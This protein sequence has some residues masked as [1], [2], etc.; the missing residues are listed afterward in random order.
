MTIRT[1]A[2]TLDINKR[3][4]DLPF[5]EAIQGDFNSLKLQVSVIED[6]IPVDLTGWTQTFFVALDNQHYVKDTTGIQA[7]AE[8]LK[9]GRFDYVFVKEAFA[10]P[11]EMETARFILEDSEGTMLT[12]MPRFTYTV[13][14][15]PAQGKVIAKTFDSDYEKFKDEIKEMMQDS[16]DNSAKA[17]DDSQKAVDNANNALQKVEDGFAD[18]NNRLEA[19]E[20][21]IDDQQ[22]VKVGGS[23]M[24]GA[25]N[26]TKSFNLQYGA[27]K[28]YIGAQTAGTVVTIKLGSITG[29]ATPYDAS[30]DIT[31]GSG[32]GISQDGYVIDP[33]TTSSAYV[34][35]VV[36]IDTVKSCSVING[37]E[38]YA[39]NTTKATNTLAI[40]QDKKQGILS[41]GSAIDIQT[42]QFTLNQ[43][44]IETSEGA[45]AKADK[46]LNDAKSLLKKGDK[47]TLGLADGYTAGTD[48]GCW[49]Q[50]ADIGGFK[51]VT[52]HA[53]ASGKFDSGIYTVVNKD[54]VPSALLPPTNIRSGAA[55]TGARSGIFEINTSGQ[56]KLGHNLTSAPTW[57]E[58]IITY[59]L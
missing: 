48:G 43:K 50:V 42:P 31:V 4:W 23:T 37:K 17:L 44:T 32:E 29:T 9:S 46:A 58:G 5:I 40:K 25:L 18:A 6:G 36:P 33:V 1:I 49:Y 35:G 56:L 28:H 57:M 20:N 7:S 59:I 24:T 8:D 11:G 19:L 39:Q 47:V 12:G 51:I 26:N 54:L 30:F 38:K 41:A 15:D 10:V 21:D 52:I 13:R 22:N 53:G 2:A 14:A 27:L 16:L 55:G 45:Q 3:R 34:T